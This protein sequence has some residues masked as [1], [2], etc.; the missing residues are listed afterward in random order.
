MDITHILVDDTVKVGDRV[1]LIRDNAHLDEIAA[2][3]H[4]ATEEAICALNKRVY[5]E[6]IDDEAEEMV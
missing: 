5:R 1:D 4:G 6:Y 2:H 3:I